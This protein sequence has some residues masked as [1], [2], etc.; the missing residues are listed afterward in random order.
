MAAVPAWAIHGKAPVAPPPIPAHTA[1]VPVCPAAALRAGRR[2]F[3]AEKLRRY[4]EAQAA[5]AWRPQA[6]PALLIAVPEGNWRTDWR[7]QMPFTRLIAALRSRPTGGVR[8]ALLPVGRLGD[9][10]LRVWT[11]PASGWE[12]PQDGRPLCEWLLGSLPPAPKASG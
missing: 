1:S 2:D 6:P 3:A 9:G 4:A 7:W 11:L 5:G 12:K 8:A 10:D